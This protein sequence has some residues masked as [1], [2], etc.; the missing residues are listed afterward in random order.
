MVDVLRESSQLSDSIY[1]DEIQALLPRSVEIRENIEG[2][3]SPSNTYQPAEYSL[4][5]PA[6]DLVP[7]F[8]DEQAMSIYPKITFTGYLVEKFEVFPDGGMKFCGRKLSFGKSNTNF[9]DNNVRY[10]GAYFYKIRTVCKIQAVVDTVTTDPASAQAALATVYMAS[11]GKIINVLC[12]ERV[13]P[14]PPNILHTTFEFKTLLPKLRWNFPLN[15]QRDIKRF[16]IFKR[17]SI[18]EPFVLLKEYD[19]DNSEIRTQVAEIAQQGNLIENPGSVLNF[20]DTTHNEGEKPIYAIA[21]VDAHG[22]SSNYGPQIKVERDRY[23]NRV[24]RTLISRPGAPKP[25][26]N[27]YLRRDTFQDAIKT[28]GYDR[29]KLIFDPEYY[30]VVREVQHSGGLVEERD[31][32]FLAIDDIPEPSFR[33]N[34]HFINVDNQKD[35]L[36]KVRIIN[37]AAPGALGDNTFA[38]PAAAFSNNNL[39]FQYGTE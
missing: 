26:P 20:I 25:Y 1:Q 6:V 28:S 37:N 14:P 21:C 19:F 31:L 12:V 22:L 35:Q 33:Y 39:S 3:I 9:I 38:V 24:K 15:K 5:V 30:R 11:E 7:F 13:P 23:T 36:V 29:I 32:N 34:F 27:L 10:G 16:Q 17:L 2:T 8:G 18:D 4:E